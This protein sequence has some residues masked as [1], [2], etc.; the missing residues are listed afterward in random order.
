MSYIE[1]SVFQELHNHKPKRVTG[2]DQLETRFALRQR[3]QVQS[4]EEDKLKVK[5]R[6]FRPRRNV[7]ADI[8][9]LEINLNGETNRGICYDSTKLME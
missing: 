4:I 1:N 7:V 2:D 9:V 6:Q 3:N 5:L 8:L